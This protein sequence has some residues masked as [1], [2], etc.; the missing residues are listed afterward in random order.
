MCGIRLIVFLGLCEL[1][2][3][4]CVYGC[5]HSIEKCEQGVCLLACL[6]NISIQSPRSD[7]I[8]VPTHV[9]TT[10]WMSKYLVRYISFPALSPGDR[11][12]WYRKL[13]SRK[14]MFWGSVWMYVYAVCMHAYIAN[15]FVYVY[16]YLY[17]YLCACTY[18][19]MNGV[20]RHVWGMA[21]WIE[22]LPCVMRGKR[23]NE[24][25]NRWVGG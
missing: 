4:V 17:V 9:R 24:Q 15:V 5:R 8:P 12:K 25:I 23:M 13:G 16:M 14:R 2:M 6:S 10:L 22:G 3:Y 1:G 7:T 19:G 18:I 20:D 11:D 21:G